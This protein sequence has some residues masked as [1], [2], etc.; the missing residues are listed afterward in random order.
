M[1]FKKTITSAAVAAALVLIPVSAASAQTWTS[2]PGGGTWQHGVEGG[3]VFSYY[4]HP[5]KS[6]TATACNSGVFDKCRQ[7]VAVKNQWARASNTASWNGGNTAFWNV[8]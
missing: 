6:H 2:T 7:V 5:G 8:L 4:H 3:A 1:R